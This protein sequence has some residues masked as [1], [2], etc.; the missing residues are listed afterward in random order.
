MPNQPPPGSTAVAWR[1]GLPRSPT[2]P[3]GLHHTKA[4]ATPSLQAL[5]RLP[6][7]SRAKSPISASPCELP[8]LGTPTRRE[9]TRTR[10]Y[11]VPFRPGSS[12]RGLSQCGMACGNVEVSTS[13]RRRLTSP[14]RSLGGAL[15]P[16]AWLAQWLEPVCWDACPGSVRGDG[17]IPFLGSPIKGAVGG[18]PLGMGSR[19]T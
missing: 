7:P 6:P 10:A 2:L 15:P 17:G 3:S 13:E 5:D 12:P 18:R 16:L 19:N 1:L 9:L 4:I 11:R 14:E 8:Q